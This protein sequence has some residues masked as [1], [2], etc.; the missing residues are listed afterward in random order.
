MKNY[1]E[2]FLDNEEWLAQCDYA[3]SWVKE[4]KYLQLETKESRKEK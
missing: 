4:Q 1:D 3:D 2:D